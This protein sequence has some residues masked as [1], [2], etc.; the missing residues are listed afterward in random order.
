MLLKEK[1]ITEVILCVGFLGK[2]IE[3]H[4]GDGSQFGIKSDIL[5]TGALC[6]AP[7]VQLKMQSVYC[8]MSS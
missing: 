6:S 8:R 2:M 7:V 4:V 5:M 3:A 1:G